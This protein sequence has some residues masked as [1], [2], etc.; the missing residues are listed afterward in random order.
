MCIK[1]SPVVHS[2][3]YIGWYL[4]STIGQFE[5]RIGPLLRTMDL[6]EGET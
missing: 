6:V 2:G 5:L 3:D 1:G 4:G